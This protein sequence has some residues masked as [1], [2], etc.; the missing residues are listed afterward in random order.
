[1]PL[2]DYTSCMCGDSTNPGVIHRA[3]GPCYVVGNLREPYK[4]MEH[5]LNRCPFAV[6]VIRQGEPEN[7][8]ESF[9][10]TFLGMESALVQ[11]TNGE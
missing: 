5:A 10:A 2:V 6:R 9:V 11:I 4:A 7:I 3:D 8:L 1:M